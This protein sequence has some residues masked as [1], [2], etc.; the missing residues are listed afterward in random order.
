MRETWGYHP[1]YPESA[2]RVCY[3]ADIG[4]EHDGIRWRPSIHM[5]RLASRIT[6][7]ITGVRVERLQEISEADA[8]AEGCAR[9]PLQDGP[10]AWWSADVDAGPALHGRTA[11]DAYR[12]LWES[13]NGP[14]SWGENPWVWVIAFKVCS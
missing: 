8:V 3:R 12:L 1:D 5:P 9:L 10:G 11:R 4:H 14:G 7:E 6:L 13:I 2:R